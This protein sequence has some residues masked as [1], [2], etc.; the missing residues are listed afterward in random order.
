MVSSSVLLHVY[1]EIRKLKTY[2]LQKIEIFRAR[3]RAR[4]CARWAPKV[5]LS[6]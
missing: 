2:Y 1:K 4:Y 6:A 3:R 5:I